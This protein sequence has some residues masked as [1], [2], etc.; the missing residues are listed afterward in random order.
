M[1]IRMIIE[2]EWQAKAASAALLDRR[3]VRIDRGVEDRRL[4]RHEQMFAWLT[5]EGESPQRSSG[6]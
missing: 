4:G 3:I 2:I 5:V 6:V 1:I